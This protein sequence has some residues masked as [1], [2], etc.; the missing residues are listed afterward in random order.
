[1]NILVDA[2]THESI[3]GFAETPGIRVYLQHDTATPMFN[4][5][6][7]HLSAG[8][9]ITIPVNDIYEVRHES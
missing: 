8:Q 7:L 2:E 5:D 4:T 1:L 6:G 9:T 3:P